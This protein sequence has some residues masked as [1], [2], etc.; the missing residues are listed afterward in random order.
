MFV[1]GSEVVCSF[2][3]FSGTSI[4]RLCGTPG[5]VSHT[6]QPFNCTFLCHPPFLIAF[7]GCG[8]GSND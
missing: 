5:L 4:F 8:S 1:F 7:T 6:S 2:P 3:L